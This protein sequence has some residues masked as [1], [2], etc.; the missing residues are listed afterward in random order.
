MFF[1]KE[2]YKFDLLGNQQKFIS[3]QGQSSRFITNQHG[4]IKLYA[5]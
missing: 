4:R 2:Y 3:S 1:E 5:F